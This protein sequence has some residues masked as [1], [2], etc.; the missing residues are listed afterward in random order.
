MTDVLRLIMVCVSGYSGSGKDEVAKVLAKKYDAL[1][2][3]LANPAKRHMADLYGFTET[4]L[5]GPSA[6]RNK[7]DL[8]YPKPSFHDAG[9]QKCGV[10]P[11]TD[12]EIESIVGKK[13][14]PEKEYWW[15]DAHPGT[16]PH[17]RP[18]MP[19]VH[20]KLGN[21][22]AFVEAGDPAFWL[23][24]REALQKYCELMN[25]M[26]ADTWIN[27]G[28][29]IHKKLAEVEIFETEEGS[30]MRCPPADHVGTVIKMM[31]YRYHRMH[32]LICQMDSPPNERET[33]EDFVVTCFADFR[34]KHEI[35][36]ARASASKTVLPVMIRVKRPS[37]P[38]PPF[39]HRSETEM[40]DIPD[41]VFDFVIDNDGTLEDLRIKTEAVMQRVI[42]PGWIP[43]VGV[44]P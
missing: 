10:H 13:P 23:S 34:H 5:F 36:L 44:L 3:G 39:N 17:F 4:Q 27:K 18:D 21:V 42:E 7:G 28:I 30:T 9:L 33:E 29:E 37:V 32:G 40:A 38:K 22:M 43:K 8:R 19:L 41:E 6:E 15:F 35:R 2:T 16:S 25:T 24:P 14:N 26:F 11:I 12:P 1:Q 20:G 31:R